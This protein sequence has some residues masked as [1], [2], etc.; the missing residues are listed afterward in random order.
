MK[1]SRFSTLVPSGAQTRITSLL[2]Y[3]GSIS[4][5]TTLEATN[6]RPYLIVADRNRWVDYVSDSS[7]LRLQGSVF[8]GSRVK[9]IFLLLFELNLLLEKVVGVLLCLFVFG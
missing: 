7:D 4:F 5:I 2:S 9:Q 8:P 3:E 6:L 1:S